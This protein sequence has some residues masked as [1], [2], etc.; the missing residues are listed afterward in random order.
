MKNITYYLWKIDLS[1]I[2][3]FDELGIY[4]MLFDQFQL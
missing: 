2:K 3:L 4:Q 1:Y